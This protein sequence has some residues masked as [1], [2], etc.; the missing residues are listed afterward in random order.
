LAAGFCPK[1]LAFARKIMGCSPPAPGSYAYER[2]SINKMCCC[3]LATCYRRS[4][5]GRTGKCRLLRMRDMQKTPRYFGYVM[6]VWLFYFFLYTVGH[7]NGATF[8]FTITLANVDRF[9]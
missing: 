2:T 8:I 5:E 7:K 3:Y 4:P 6:F 9:Q 1:N